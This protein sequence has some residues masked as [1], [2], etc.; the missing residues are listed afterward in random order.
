MIPDKLKWNSY[1]QNIIAQSPKADT[2]RRAR[3]LQA[4]LGFD[5]YAIQPAVE[6]G[7]DEVGNER[8]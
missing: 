7:K 6:I 8:N 2:A 3:D 4:R 1:L 5:D